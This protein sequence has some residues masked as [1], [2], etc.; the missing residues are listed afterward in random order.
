ME[1][2]LLKSS[3]ELQA[4]S[5]RM[6]SSPAFR[7]SSIAAFDSLLWCFCS[8]WQGLTDWHFNYQLERYWKTLTFFWNKI[9]LKDSNLDDKMQTNQEWKMSNDNLWKNRW[10]WWRW[11][12]G[13]VCLAFSGLVCRLNH[14]HPGLDGLAHSGDDPVEP[15]H[16][17]EKY[18]G[19]FVAVS[20]ITMVHSKN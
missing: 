20:L 13:L 7:L 10:W 9:Y 1:R 17:A 2:C 4:S 3:M 16:N 15:I 5:H 11:T 8:E 6:H 19:L 18:E 12:T 14:D